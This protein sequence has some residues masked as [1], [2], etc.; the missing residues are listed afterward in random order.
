MRIDR[1]A[2]TASITSLGNVLQNSGST[3]LA[4][5]TL[6]G[7]TLN[8]GTAA[9]NGSVT[10]TVTATGGTLSGNGT[11][12]SLVANGATLAPQLQMQPPQVPP[13]AS[14]QLAANPRNTLRIAFKMNDMRYTDPRYDPW[15]PASPMLLCGGD[16]DP[17]V[18]FLN[19]LIM[20]GNWTG[21]PTGAVTVLDVN[22][23]PGAGGALRNQA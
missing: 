9:L 2:V 11:F 18:F 8:G 19:T 16:Q 4:G 13:A 5:G 6:G 3:S 21:L 1:F 17:T 12:G 10:G 15:F 20:A 7:F 14:V 23:P 22:A